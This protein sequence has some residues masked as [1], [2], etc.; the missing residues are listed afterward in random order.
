MDLVQKG[1]KRKAK[2][3]EI[4][5]LGIAFELSDKENTRLFSLWYD[6]LV[7]KSLVK[8]IEGD[9]EVFEKEFNEFSNTYK[10]DG[11]GRLH[12]L[13][14]KTPPVISI[15]GDKY[16]AVITYISF[17]LKDNCNEEDYYKHLKAY[18][19]YNKNT[20]EPLKEKMSML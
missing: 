7:R 3:E 11:R 2:K 18:D 5:E 19:E 9:K 13:W 14:T 8:V 15:E 10:N 17:E 4:K 6:M 16:K 1:L 20:Y 12:S